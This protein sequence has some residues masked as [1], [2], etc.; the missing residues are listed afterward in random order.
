MATVEQG[1]F[2]SPTSN[3]KIPYQ[4]IL[5]ATYT[6][7]GDFTT[8][9]YLHGAFN[10]VDKV[11]QYNH[12]DSLGFKTI[13]DERNIVI[14]VPYAGKLGLYIDWPEQIDTY[15]VMQYETTLMKEWYPA[16]LKQYV[17]GPATDNPSRYIFGISMGG[18]GV[19]NFIAKYPQ[20]F[21]QA[22]FL[23]PLALL[24]LAAIRDLIA[25]MINEGSIAAHTAMDALQTLLG[26][27]QDLIGEA[28]AGLAGAVTGLPTPTDPSQPQP[29]P[30][31][32]PNSGKPNIQIPD[33]VKEALNTVAGNVVDAVFLAL[34]MAQEG[35]I[36]IAGD[37]N[38]A[39]AYRKVKKHIIMGDGVDIYKGTPVDW[40]GVETNIPE[41]K[42]SLG[43][44][45]SGPDTSIS[46]PLEAALGA[47]VTA[48]VAWLRV[49][50]VSIQSLYFNNGTHSYRYWK[51]A[52]KV[53]FERFRVFHDAA[54]GVGA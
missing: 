52:A 42:S 27:P 34:Q 23:S 47:L 39:P 2:Q 33:S 29:Q 14:F 22:G 18:Q 36:D 3:T 16:I 9:L 49:R 17:S 8:A 7:G 5:P 15:K 25:T 38:Y 28:L 1:T 31:P 41:P 48:D 54:T 24:D 35:F 40:G 37:V 21:A 51:D 6:P 53:L 45:L 30:T 10:N 43:A 46:D 26:V 20:Y 4:V 19:W 13:A 12:S 50:G 11:L 44:M 32:A